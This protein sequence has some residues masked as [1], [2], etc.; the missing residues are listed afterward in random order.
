MFVQTR[1]SRATTRISMRRIMMNERQRSQRVVAL[2][3]SRSW[4]ARRTG[5]NACCTIRIDRHATPCSCLRFHEHAARPRLAVCPGRPSPGDC[6]RD[7]PSRLATARRT[8]HVSVGNCVARRM[9]LRLRTGRTYATDKGCVWAPE[10][11]TC[12][13]PKFSLPCYLTSIR[14]KKCPIFCG[15]AKTIFAALHLCRI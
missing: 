11:V 14:R 10:C 13:L 7:R 6:A 4:S 8:R 3:C 9:V 2:C 1:Q 15:R 12:A 5:S